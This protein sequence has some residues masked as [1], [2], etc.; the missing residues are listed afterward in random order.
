MV[1]R[2]EFDKYL[3][4]LLK[5]EKDNSNLK[6]LTTGA[7]TLAI[8]ATFFGGFFTL[9]C[10]C[11][12]FF[13]YVLIFPLIV[14][15]FC[16]VWGIR[17]L[18]KINKIKKYFEDTYSNKVVEY[19][20]EGKKYMLDRKSYIMSSIFEKSQFG[21][22]FNRYDGED[23][24]KI[25]IQSD[26]GSASNTDLIL[27]DLD[28]RKEEKD[29]DGETRTYT[30]FEGIFGYIDFPCKFN[31][32]LCINTRHYGE[33]AME[34]VELEDINFNDNFSVYG[35]NQ[36]EARYILTPDM[37]LKLLSFKEIAKKL[38]ITMIGNRMYVGFSALRLFET[39]NVVNGD[40][41]SMFR[42]FYT[43]IYVL[44]T[45]IEEIKNN[46]KVFKI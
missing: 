20:L 27:C 5:D 18:I 15:A 4:N 33:V 26:D 32:A 29:E 40:V 21:G 24:L 11:M 8:L 3:D 39:K 23:W 28:V 36:I 9:F 30:V 38:K 37:M 45:L 41:V 22:N 17:R 34:K 12:S 16:L 1:S 43:P 25:N 14:S 7:A 10:I 44:F 19:L 35:S 31:C 46:D 2:E 42:N 6:Y 13:E